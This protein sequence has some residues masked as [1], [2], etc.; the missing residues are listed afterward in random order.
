MIE[1]INGNIFKGDADII[2]HQVNTH[3]IMGAGIALQIKE[4]FPDV[5]AVYREKSRE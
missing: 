1:I 5:Y 2:C 3:G 4:K